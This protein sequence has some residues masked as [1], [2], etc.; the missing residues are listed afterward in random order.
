MLR[1]ILRIQQRRNQAGTWRGGRNLDLIPIE[2][3]DDAGLNQL[4]RRRRQKRHGKP[5]SDG[6]ICRQFI[7]HAEKSAVDGQKGGHGDEIG[8][9]LN[10]SGRAGSRQGSQLPR[11]SGVCRENGFHRG[12]DLRTGRGRE[13]TFRP[14]RI[15]F[16]F[17]RSPSS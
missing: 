10:G 5:K 6:R 12:A 9:S 16:F 3:R 4:P 1:Q 11:G 7:D 17:I 14:S 2:L 13:G 15:I 8:V